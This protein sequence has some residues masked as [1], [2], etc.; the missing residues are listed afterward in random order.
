MNKIYYEK[1]L[2]LNEVKIFKVYQD[3][4]NFLNTIQDRWVVITSG[5]N[6]KELVQLIHDSEKVIGII[7]F[8]INVTYHEE[9]S[10]NYQRIHKVVN[11][12]AQVEKEIHDLNSKYVTYATLSA[13]SSGSDMVKSAEKTLE[14]MLFNKFNKQNKDDDNKYLDFYHFEEKIEMQFRV[15]AKLSM[16][17]SKITP[18]KVLNELMNLNPSDGSSIATLFSEKAKDILHAIIYLYSTNYIYRPFNTCFAKHNYTKVMYTIAVCLREL[19]KR[20]ELKMSK[21]TILYRGVNIS[22]KSKYQ[23]GKTGYWPAFSSTSKSYNVA[24][25]YNGANTVFEIHLSNYYPHPHIEMPNG[26]SAYATELEVLLYPYFALI[27]T[28]I[29]QKDGKTF[30]TVNQDENAFVLSINDTKFINFWKSL[31]K[32][33]I[34]VSINPLIVKMKELGDEKINLNTYFKNEFWSDFN[35][36]FNKCHDNHKSYIQGTSSVLGGIFL[37]GQPLRWYKSEMTTSVCNNVKITIESQVSNVFD[38]LYSQ[39]KKDL[40][41]IVKTEIIKKYDIS[42]ERVEYLLDNIMKSFEIGLSFE[43][44]GIGELFEKYGIFAIFI[45][46]FPIFA[47]MRENIFKSEYSLKEDFRIASQEKMKIAIRNNDYNISQVTQEFRQR[48]NTKL[49]EIYKLVLD[50]LKAELF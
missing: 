26:W 2:K 6:G 32:N 40:I 27:V 33:E 45:V 7:I 15:V 42:M 37:A 31:I 1:L 20:P 30:I 19:G 46:I 43:Y 18:E 3:V 14:N 22:D 34:E 48:F 24:K 39:L 12:F 44:K 8:C 23:I 5:T 21:G 29:Q 13:V 36:V 10:K 47:D 41:S 17:S 50:T 4:A 11:S 16:G 28:S 38:F 49:Q 35:D 9:W 25:N